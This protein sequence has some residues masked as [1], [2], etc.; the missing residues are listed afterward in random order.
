MK[1]ILSQAIAIAPKDGVVLTDDDLNFNPNR[2]AK[3]LRK[4]TLPTHVVET[5]EEAAQINEWVKMVTDLRE[6]SFKV[7]DQYFLLPMHA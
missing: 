6:D 1:N 4:A 3:E 7:G 2:F 5:Q